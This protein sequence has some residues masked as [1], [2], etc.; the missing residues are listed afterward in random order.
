MPPGPPYPTA[1]MP[2]GPKARPLTWPSLTCSGAGRSRSPRA[3]K[4]T[5]PPRTA[6]DAISRGN[7]S[8]RTEGHA[9][10]IALGD[11]EEAKDFRDAHRESACKLPRASRVSPCFTT[12][13]ASSIAT[14]SRSALAA[15][16]NATSLRISSDLCLGLCFLGRFL[17][18]PWFFLRDSG[19][20]PSVNGRV[21]NANAGGHPAKT[22]ITRPRRTRAGVAGPDGSDRRRR[23]R[24]S[25]QPWPRTGPWPDPRSSGATTP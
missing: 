20:N 2:S 10:D 17:E 22:A 5:T 12:S 19:L 8:V 16:D 25:P 21:S 6:I 14:S 3:S 15:S 4:S 24:F 13:K 9:R 11:V 7:H 18:R 1:I 23:A